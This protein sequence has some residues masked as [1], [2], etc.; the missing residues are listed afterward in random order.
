MK[1]PQRK[2][3]GKKKLITFGHRKVPTNFY[4]MELREQLEW[5]SKFLD[6]ISPH[7]STSDSSTDPKK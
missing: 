5:A 6:G 2:R 3:K 4:D 7:D 1:L